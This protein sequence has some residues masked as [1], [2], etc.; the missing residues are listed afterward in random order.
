M[1]IILRSAAIAALVVLASCGKDD[2][3]GS[4]GEMDEQAELLEQTPL[5]AN[6]V[7]D[8]VV[9]QGATKEEGTPPTPN[10]A[11]TMDIS[12]TGKSAFQDVGFVV[13]VSSNASLAG[14]YLRF[15]DVDGAFAD[16]YY[17]IDLSDNLSKKK[18]LLQS[19][20]G[21]PN[22]TLQ[23]KTDDAQFQIGF[24]STIKPGKF[25]YEICV[26]DAN[27]NISNPQEVCVTVESWGGNTAVVGEWKMETWVDNNYPEDLYEAG[28]EKC[29]TDEKSISCV[30][31]SLTVT[32]MREFCQEFEYQNII[33][34]ADGTYSENE[35]STSTSK[36][37]SITEPEEMTLENIGLL[38]NENAYERSDLYVHEGSGK[39]SYLAEENKIV[40]VQFMAKETFEYNGEVEI[41]PIEEPYLWY[42]SGNANGELKL[43][44]GKL[45]L[46]SFEETTSTFIK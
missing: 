30:E 36:P 13:N 9:I 45:V 20:L 34:N 1:K 8:N 21:K 18:P 35:S 12:N 2:N 43:I 5:E 39:W 6:T 4:A 27:G 44:D 10:D 41:Y 25:C 38:C 15:K 29:D 33:I 3:G 32:F 40:F 46:S 19:R 24:N 14:A 31:G 16:T 37:L 23:S 22:R 11:I 42:G 17:N 26:Y 7:A 28:V